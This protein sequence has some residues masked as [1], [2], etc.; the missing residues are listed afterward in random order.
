V[1]RLE[2]SNS[3]DKSIFVQVDPWAC[4]Y[5][6]KRGE[7]IELVMECAADQPT[8]SIDEYDDE[9]RIVTLV[10]CDEFFISLN[11]ELIHWK[12]YQSNVS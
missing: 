10:D 11:G 9:N 7:R 8:F 12:N 6:L 3:K 5:K 2:F 1:Y 4:L